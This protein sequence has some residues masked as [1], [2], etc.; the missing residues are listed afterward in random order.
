[1][2]APPGIVWERAVCVLRM[3]QISWFGGGVRKR[4][5]R[6]RRTYRRAGAVELA[7]TKPYYRRIGP[8]DSLCL[9]PGGCFAM[10][11]YANS[12]CPELP[13][14]TRQNVFVV[15]A[16]YN[17]GPA[18]ESV[19]GEVTALY[20]NVV[21]VDDGSSDDTFAGARKCRVHVLRHLINRGQGAA[22]QTGIDYAL[23]RGARYVVT[24]DADGQ[25]R[26]EDVGATVSPIYRGE[27][28]I[29]LGSRF[30]GRAVDM[31]M[32]RRLAL[33]AAV[34]FTRIVSRVKVTDTHNGLRAFSRRA[35]ERINLTLD[36]MAHA[37]EIIDSVRQSGLP[38]C[39]VPVQ[40]R[41]TKYSRA[42]GQSTRGA[43]RILIHYLSGRL[44][45]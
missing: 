23:K 12:T 31:P 37:S 20:P 44:L 41:Y 3:L 18:I 24:F 2:D 9:G 43:F 28:D 33:R 30:L 4:R 19:V 35:A 29:C 27:Y 25:H 11:K 17:E 13:R 42:K 14:E 34:L 45:R 22:L 10:A 40:V 6:P 1:L 32:K 16:A 26:V 8:A 38:Y 21:V 5:R 7:N 15:I 39:E 36:R